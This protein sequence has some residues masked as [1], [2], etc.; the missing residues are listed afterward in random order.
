MGSVDSGSSALVAAVNLAASMVA[1]ALGV[2]SCTAGL[3]ATAWC[4]T[5]VAAADLVVAVDVAVLDLA[6]A[7][8]VVLGAEATG[9][10]SAAFVIFAGAG[11]L[12]FAAAGFLAVLAGCF[13]GAAVVGAA[14]WR[15]TGFLALGLSPADASTLAS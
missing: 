7:G 3:V 12:G 8:V 6:A 13:T 10:A 15:T 14:F 2:V 1:G 9:L 5:D 11:F 4:A